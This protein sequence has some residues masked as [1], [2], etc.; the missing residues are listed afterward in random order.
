MTVRHYYATELED[1]GRSG[2]SVGAVIGY[3]WVRGEPR[4]D[5]PDGCST[6]AMVEHVELL[7]VECHSYYYQFYRVTRGARRC[8]GIRSVERRERPDWFAVLDRIVWDLIT[9]PDRV[10]RPTRR[11][12]IRE[13]RWR[14]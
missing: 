9:E 14:M 12:D 6:P 3:R 10:A 4:S 7:D 1:L 11:P 13:Q 5:Y 2:A 8:T